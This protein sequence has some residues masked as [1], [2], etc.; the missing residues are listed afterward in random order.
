MQVTVTD[1]TPIEVTFTAQNESKQY[2]GVGYKLGEQFNE[3][4][5]GRWAKPQN[6]VTTIMEYDTLAELPAVT[7]AGVYT[8]TA[9]YSDET[10]YG[11]QSATFTITKSRSGQADDQQREYSHLWSNAHIECR[12]RFWHPVR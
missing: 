5:G 1:K 8:V 6:T 4:D 11:E 7:T 2:T 10:Y 9:F 12:G 3:A